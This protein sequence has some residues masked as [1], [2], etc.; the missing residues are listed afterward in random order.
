MDFEQEINELKLAVAELRKDLEREVAN[1]NHQTTGLLYRLMALEEMVYPIQPPAEQDN[2]KCC[3]TCR[4][5]KPNSTDLCGKECDNYSAHEP[6]ADEKYYCLCGEELKP[7]YNY[8]SWFYKCPV[9]HNPEGRH[10][11][12]YVY[13][14][15]FKTEQECIAE[16]D[17]LPKGEGK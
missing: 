3:Q 14:G 15:G 7:V 1:L 2:R 13:V 12:H 5:N 16:L 17:K 8:G 10:G 4:F 11:S 9:Y 6:K